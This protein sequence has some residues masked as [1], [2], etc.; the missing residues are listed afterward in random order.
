MFV[1]YIV[2]WLGL[3]PLIKYTGSTALGPLFPSTMLI[4]EM[5]ASDIWSKYSGKDK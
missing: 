2:A 5:G 4:S 1:G 3:I